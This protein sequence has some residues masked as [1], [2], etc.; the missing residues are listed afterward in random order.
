M[1]DW[2][3]YLESSSFSSVTVRDWRV[4]LPRLKHSVPGNCYFV[5]FQ[6]SLGLHAASAPY[7]EVTTGL[8]C[9][10]VT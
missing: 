4:Y 2:G 1:K 8:D 7:N 6:I 5:P 3:R 10:Y 9:L